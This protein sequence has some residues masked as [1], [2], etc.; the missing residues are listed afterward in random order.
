VA[1]PA[2]VGA[3][4]ERTDRQDRPPI[5]APEALGLARLTPGLV[6]SVLDPRMESLLHA[7][8]RWRRRPGP[9]RTVVDQVYLVPDVPTFLEV[10]AAW[11]GRRFF[12]I[13]IDDPA[14][15]LP[16]LRAFRPARVVRVLPAGGGSDPRPVTT[17]QAA[18]RAVALAWTAEAAAEGEAPSGGRVPR[19]LG[20]LP[21]GLVFSD[22][23]SPSLAGA[24]A[25]A[26]GRFQPLVRLGPIAG[27]ADGTSPGEPRPRPK[28]FPDRLSL[29]EARAFAREVER[30]AGAVA[31]PHAGLGDSCDFL[32][33]AGDWPYAYRNDEEGG[34]V[35]G[36]HAVDD[37]I[38][39]VLDGPGGG[40]AGARTRWAFAGRLLGGP[41]ASVYRAMCSLFLEPEPAVLWDTYRGGQFWSDYAMTDAG[42][43]LG[44]L[45]PGSPAPVHRAGLEADLA[46]WHRVFDPV[47]RFGWIM[48]NSS[49]FPR[50]FAIA[51]GSGRP[52]DLPPGRPAAV[53]IVHSFSAA[54]PTDPSTIAGRWLENGAFVYYGAMN[55]PYLQA[56]RPPKLIA[57]LAAGEMPLAAALRQGEHEPFGRPWRL[58][59]LGDPLY[60]FRIRD[61]RRTEG[62]MAPATW[63]APS[64]GPARRPA[65]EITARSA[66][67]APP[68]SEA[69]RLEWCLSRA[70]ASLCRPEASSG[71]T[72]QPETVDAKRAD[73]RSI[74]LEI[75][76]R[77]LE[78]A[79]G[80]VHAEVVVDTLLHSGGEGRL[81]DWLLN[82]PAEECPARLVRTIETLAMSRVARLTASREL[83]PALDLWDNLIRRPWPAGSEFP[84]HL[85][86]R[87]AAMASSSPPGLEA[88][89]DH[90]RRAALDL[91]AIPG[92][93]PAASVVRSELE[94]VDAERRS[95]GF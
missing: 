89:R 66:Q 36:E 51:G 46:A 75:D 27:A 9:E 86:E 50:Q 12:P 31:G 2:P 54:D 78:P 59:Y 26:A 37:L 64:P 67:A 55:E 42:G 8:D 49:G 1:P 91:A 79:L 73:W 14:W 81:W 87:L 84:A 41:A 72:P 94:R 53:S 28:G 93:Y 4:P 25:L 69:G 90:L 15:T 80:P 76:R 7:A 11:D 82:I 29:D 77:R 5:A 83:G 32:T 16:F 6:T 3:A 63:Q 88:Y 19:G 85:T 34:N 44:R 23:E 95:S 47:N 65:A 71:A 52:A 40:L 57:E 62:R 20:P 10:I 30:L 58:V 38:G 13:L 17:W 39:R 22:P 70:I 21:P 48:V 68:A 33:L 61:A 56:F 35:R 92:P 24:V 43:L 45:W 74:L 18:E 60:R